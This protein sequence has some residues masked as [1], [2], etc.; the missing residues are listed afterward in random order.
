MIFIKTVT[1]KATKVPKETEV[2]GR[3]AQDVIRDAYETPGGKM[4]VIPAR[5]AGNADNGRKERVGA[6]CRVS[7]GKEEQA[8]SYETQYQ[9]YSELI[10]G[11]S[12]WEFVG[13]YADR[14][15]S[16]TS[17]KKRDQF[18]RMIE[19][20]KQGKIDKILV[21]SVSRF[22][23]N[24]E[25]CLHY[26]R[27]LKALS[28]AVAVYFETQHI[29]SLT[30]TSEMQIITASMIAQGE[31]EGKSISI[32]WRVKKNF[33]KGIIYPVWSLLGYVRDGNSKWA[34]EPRGAEI[35]ENIYALYLEGYSSPR[36][37]DILNQ[38]GIETATGTTTWC[39]GSVLGILRN[40]KYKG[41]ALCQKTISVDL[42][43]HITIKNDGRLDQYYHEDHHP[44]IISREAWQRVQDMID[45]RV[46]RYRAARYKKPRV[47]MR[48]GLMGFFVIDPSW[49][50]DDVDYLIFRPSD[51][52]PAGHEAHATN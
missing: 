44:A 5:N 14:G 13:I 51:I 32:K 38:S 31:S 50:E 34:I 23:R 46:Y 21:K 9:Y 7:T 47:I 37:A 10:Q 2:G 26:T 41:D 11:N 18:L 1:I 24:V 33:Q 49:S 52:I 29:N 20:C 40:E 27:L 28:P 30:E 22:S 19:D 4:T 12:A 48:G 42:F 3:S 36:I 43:N 39:S 16:G 15:L 6:Y 35:V 45:A 25:D 8:S 17:V